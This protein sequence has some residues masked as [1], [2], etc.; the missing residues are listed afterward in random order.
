MHCRLGARIGPDR[1]EC[2]FGPWRLLAVLFTE[3]FVDGC[4][5]VGSGFAGGCLAEFLA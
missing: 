1:R 3:C 4:A 2:R 5:E